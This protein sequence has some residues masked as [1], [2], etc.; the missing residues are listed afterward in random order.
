ML[1]NPNFRFVTIEDIADWLDRPEFCQPQ[2]RYRGK[3]EGKSKTRAVFGIMLRVIKVI[4]RP[5][6]PGC[7]QRHSYFSSKSLKGITKIHSLEFVDGRGKVA[8]RARTCIGCAKCNEEKW[9]ECVNK[10][11]VGEHGIHVFEKEAVKSLET[12]NPQRSVEE[13]SNLQSGDLIAVV[14]GLAS[15]SYYVAKVRQDATDVRH[16]I[17][18][19]TV[20]ENV[21]QPVAK[22]PR[23]TTRSATGGVVVHVNRFRA[24]EN[25]TL[26]WTFSE[27][28]LT[29][30]ASDVI[31]TKFSIC[32]LPGR[33]M[34]DRMDGEDGNV[35]QMD[36]ADHQTI[37]RRLSGKSFKIQQ[38]QSKK[39]EVP[40]GL[41]AGNEFRVTINKKRFDLKVPHGKKGGDTFYIRIAKEGN[42]GGG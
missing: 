31:H 1:L 33:K 27:K 8:H 38:S 20:A 13:C 14:S 17:E 35:Y 19:N 37:L 26:K 6:L 22:K 10:K 40:R 11:W 12:W 18:E 34:N 4:P 30:R 28:P 29:V 24:L 23:K 16:V 7:V 9:E 32:Q 21:V 15:R 5:G 2:T 42:G 3:M 41:T 25:S 36:N 39:I